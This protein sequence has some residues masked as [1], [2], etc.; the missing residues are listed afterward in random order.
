MIYIHRMHGIKK[1]KNLSIQNKHL[2]KKKLIV[3]GVAEN[4]RFF[5]KALIW[6]KLFFLSNFLNN[7]I[8]KLLNIFITWKLY[9]MA[10]CI[11]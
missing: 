7:V 3:V 9:L 8:T 6:D 1:K 4:L 10:N 11:H 5:F 2:Y